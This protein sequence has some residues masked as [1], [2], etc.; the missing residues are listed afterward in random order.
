MAMYM[1]L[2]LF[3]RRNRRAIRRERIFRDRTNPLDLWTDQQ[4]HAKYRFSRLA[5]LNIIDLLQDQLQ[6]TTSRNHALPPSLQVFIALRFLGHG[7]LTDD[8]GAEPHGVS[9]P[10]AC[11]AVRRVVRALCRL[12]SR[13][14]KF[15]NTPEEVQHNQRSF[16]AV[17]GFPHVVGAIDGTHVRLH[18]VILGPDEYV[19]VNRKGKVPMHFISSGSSKIDK[20]SLLWQIAR[21]NCPKPH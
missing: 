5:C 19:Y 2:G 17:R 21:Q 10:T 8:A 12:K 1:A 6:H 20:C 18:G 11:R 13:F 9:V 4:M 15:P 7:S 14:I 3:E 16:M